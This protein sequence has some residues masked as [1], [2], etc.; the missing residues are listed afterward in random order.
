MT[1]REMRTAIETATRHWGGQCYVPHTSLPIWWLWLA[2]DPEESSPLD[3][4]DYT[5][6]QALCRAE[7]CDV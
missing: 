5:D 3:A 6:M 2:Q 7:V 4:W 1:D